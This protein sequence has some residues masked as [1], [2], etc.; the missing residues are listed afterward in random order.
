MPQ[1]IIKSV[2]AEF[3]NGVHR[4]W[5]NR[6][7][8]KPNYGYTITFE[9]GVTGDCAAASSPTF[10]IAIGTEVTYE[11][12]PKT[13]GSGTS[14]TKIKK[15]EVAPGQGYSQ[16][17]SAPAGKSSYNDPTTTKRI[18]FSMCQ[19]I[20]QKQFTNAGRE[21]DGIEQLNA[22]AGYYHAWV[23]SD[24]PVSDPQYRDKISRKYY[25][26]QLAVDCIPFK[27]LLLDKKE[28]IIQAAEELL[29]PV[30]EIGNEA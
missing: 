7:T 17:T 5:M 24:L 9:N 28:S 11:S 10:P 3:Q 21:P 20:A 29:H 12:A 18:S 1:S 30:N 27:A 26:L 19:A 2:N 22:L 8:N 6:F 23:I 4:T 15:L 14:I 13:N 25:A 16:G